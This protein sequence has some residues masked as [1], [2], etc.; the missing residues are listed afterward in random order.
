MAA[1]IAGP[2]LSGYVGT[3]PCALPEEL[4]AEGEA[5]S[6]LGCLFEG[7]SAFEVE[8]VEFVL[9]KDVVHA[10][11]EEG[12][13]FDDELD[14][15]LFA[16]FLPGRVVVLHTRPVGLPH[17]LDQAVEGVAQEGE[18]VEGLCLDFFSLPETVYFGGEVDLV[19]HFVVLVDDE[20]GDH[21]AAEQSSQ[22]GDGVVVFLEGAGDL[23]G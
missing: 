12:Y 22:V 15:E 19:G 18:E 11:L 16:D 1:D 9:L 13:L 7:E 17:V 20:H 2:C 10:V 23:Q 8:A 5:F 4:C 21:D 14:V 6:D 3:S